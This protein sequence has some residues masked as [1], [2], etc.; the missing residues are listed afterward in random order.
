MRR[1]LG[2]LVLLP[3]PA[4]ARS[5]YYEGGVTVASGDYVFTERTTS[6]SWLTG[7]ALEH[8]RTALR[9]NVPLWFQTSTLV[10]ST[11]G[12]AVPSGGD[13]YGGAVRDGQPTTRGRGARVPVA[14]DAAGD[15]RMVIGDPM[16]QL[17][18][19]V[20]EPLETSVRASISAKVPVTSIEDFGTGE[21]DFGSGLSIARPLGSRWLGALDLSYWYLG[22]PP[23]LDFQDPVAVAASVTRFAGDWAFAVSGWASSPILP[24][25]DPPLIVGAGLTRRMGFGSWS[26]Y[27]SFGLTDTAADVGAAALWRVPLH[28]H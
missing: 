2:L 6:V 24:D 12:G 7:L 5:T 9:A 16:L 26:S 15:F 27:L 8:G 28:A 21:W 25:Y 13:G 14:P 11:G 17:S 20:A 23:T 1:Q 19:A 4:A 10:S 22:D 3:A 18:V